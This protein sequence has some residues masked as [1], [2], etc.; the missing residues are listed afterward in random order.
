MPAIQISRRNTVICVSALL[1]IMA[2]Q[3]VLTA[4]ANTITWDENDH[5]YS[6]YR[7]WKHGDFGLN[8]EHPPL[9]KLLATL[10]LLDMQLN[11]PPLQDR[12]YRLQA[13]LG[14]K[15]FI[16]HNDADKIVFRTRMAALPLALLLALFVFLA[17]QEMFGTGAGLIALALVTFDPTVLAHSALVTTDIGQACFMLWT[18]YALYRYAQAPSTRRIIVVGIATGLAL[19]SKHSAVL[20]LPIFL[21]L[22]TVEIACGPRLTANAQPAET[23][24]RRTLRYAKLLIVASAIAIVILWASYGFRYA[25]REPGLQLNP[26]MSVQLAKVPGTARREVL[27]AIVQAHILP[28]SYVYG[29][30]HVLFSADAFH[31]FVLGKAYPR[32]VW[33]YFPVAMLIKSSLTFLIL[34]A[35]TV[36][37]AAT[38]RFKQ[39]RALLYLAIPSALYLIISMIGGENIGIRH[40]LP[41]YI[42][43][44]VAIGGAAW[45]LIQRNRIWTYTLI[46]LLIFQAISVTRTWPT[47][48]AYANEAAGGPSN[49]HK[50][51]SDSSVDWAQQLHDVKHYIDAH[52][53]H[54]CWFLYFGYGIVDYRYYNIPCKPLPTVESIWLGAPSDAPAEIDGPLFISATD[55]SGFE[56]GPDGLNPYE[57]FKQLKPTAVIDYS[58]FVYNGHFAI[59]L[60]SALAHAQKAEI[61]LAAGNQQAALAE[62]QQAIALAPDSASVNI[63]MG[64]ALDTAG[65]RDQARAYYQKALT[66][67]QTVQPSFQDGLVPMLKARLAQP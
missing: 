17:A 40:V 16:F 20:L 60:A 31:S 51:L 6:G 39:W 36:W 48:I 10:P 3:L 28:Q 50:Y 14:G 9:V 32:A 11:E 26:P 8:P 29:M 45:A 7:M 15:D 53:I 63:T 52:N 65:R 56:F 33:F 46:A 21:V 2:V 23:A 54:D 18:I 58:V 61:Q 43:C 47:Y 34:L 27:K 57:Q 37:A 42:F 30:A 5:I 62:A 41:I 55:L 66:L 12:A 13:V 25:A 67:A 1:L 59:P 44:I 35:V 64:H 38:R 22:A 49:V 4:R 19:A 24:S